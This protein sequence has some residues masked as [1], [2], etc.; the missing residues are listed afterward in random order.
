MVR[1]A[2]DVAHAGLV[3]NQAAKV[4]ISSEGRDLAQGPSTAAPG[5]PPHDLAE[6]LLDSEVAKHE[7]AANVKVLSTRSEMDRTLL[8]IKPR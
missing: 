2:A 5:R 8:D 4:S 6:A 1:A 7:L 3:Q